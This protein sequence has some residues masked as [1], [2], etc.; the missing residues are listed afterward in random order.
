MRRERSV[1]FGMKSTRV[2]GAVE[3]ANDIGGLL[4]VG[5]SVPKADRGVTSRHVD[6]EHRPPDAPRYVTRW[7]NDVYP[8]NTHVVRR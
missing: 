6:R 4:L 5:V 3:I 2:L 1:V 8:R 7:G